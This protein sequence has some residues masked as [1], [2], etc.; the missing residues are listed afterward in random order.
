MLEIGI[1][2]LALLVITPLLGRYMAKIFSDT[3]PLPVPFLGRLGAEEMS[4]SHYAAAMLWFNFIG[5][6]FLFLLLVCQ[7]FLPLN[8]ENLSGPEPLLALNIA[9]SFV[10][11]TNWQAYGGEVTLSYLSQMLGLTVQNFFSAATGSAVLLALIRGLTRKSMETLGNFWA[12]LARTIV[13]LLLPLSVIFSLFLVSQGV[14]QNLKPYIKLESGTLPT[15]IPMGPVASQIAIKQL[16]T[17]GGGFFNANSAHPFENPTPLSNFLES[18]AI[19]CIPAAATFMYG[20]MIKSPKEGWILF[21]TML[22]F[23]VGG[24]ALALASEAIDNPVLSVN[25]VLE[26]KEIRFGTSQSILWAV[27]TTAT[28]NGSVNNML[29]SLSPLAGGVALFNMMIGEVIFGGLGVGLCGM[30]MFVLLT[31]FIAGLM[32]GRTPEYLGK[33]IE[34]TEMRW[35]MLAI[36]A[37]GTLILAGSGIASVWPAALSSLA[38]RGPHGLTEILYAFSSAAGNNGSAFN[39]LDANTPFYNLGLGLAM[40]IARGAILISSLAIAGSLVKKSPLARSIDTLRTDTPL[41]GILLTTVVLM[42]G[43]L[44]FFPALALGPIVEHFLMLENEAF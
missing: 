22:V 40:L 21:A 28:S 41:F 7:G 6:I 2:I 32:I 42:I 1:F 24:L 8:P 33:K 34:K 4:W 35:M 39:G 36:L 14:I 31:V 17:N 30:L 12:D 29:S 25:P 11:N 26:G 38:N 9:V 19:V 5:L 27:S 3:S 10:T 43:A 37:P 44:T 23:W 20:S 13:Y 15:I 18:L 16:G